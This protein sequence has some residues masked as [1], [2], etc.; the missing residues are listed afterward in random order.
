[1]LTGPKQAKKNPP[2]RSP[3]P[4]KATGSAGL[5][6]HVSSLITAILTGFLTPSEF[7]SNL[8]LLIIN[9]L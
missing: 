3:V 2:S 6:V 9:R 7:A 1:M 5:I 8:M 4:S